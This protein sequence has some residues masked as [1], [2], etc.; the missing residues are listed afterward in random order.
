[1][2]GI[3]LMG[4]SCGKRF[5]CFE[6]PSLPCPTSTFQSVVKQLRPTALAP[7]ERN[8]LN[9]AFGGFLT[10]SQPTGNVSALIASVHPDSF[11]EDRLPRRYDGDRTLPHGR[12]Y[13]VCNNVDGDDGSTLIRELNFYKAARISEC[14]IQVYDA[15]VPSRRETIGL[16]GMDTSARERIVVQII[17]FAQSGRAG[18]PISMHLSIP[19]VIEEVH[20][21]NVLD[22]RRPMALNWLLQSI[23]DLHIV[24]NDEGERK[25]CFPFRDALIE[26]AELLPSLVDQSRGGGNFDKLVGLYL[27]Q[28]GVSGLVFPSARSDAMTRTENGQLEDFHGWSF[29]DYRDA[30]Q[31]EIVAFF[32]LRPEWPRTLIVE[33]GDDHTPQ[34][35]AFAE[36]FRILM[37]KGFPSAD[38]GFAL[39]GIEQ[40]IKAYHLVDSMEAAARFRLPRVDDDQL[41]S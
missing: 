33:G 31:P 17:P 27:R 18:M 34:P 32:E 22:L 39:R 24:L 28:L 20:V 7:S 41:I 14:H 38:G 8:F 25:R 19:V 23:P 37:T 5:P 21:E 10:G 13:T 9:A 16:L 40:R 30:P 1:M 6:R 26:F 12:Y 35:A 4:E 36:E 15:A 2:P 3:V 11:H 29:V